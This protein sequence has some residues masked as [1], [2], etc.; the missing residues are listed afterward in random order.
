M[1]RFYDV[2]LPIYEGMVVYPG[3]PKPEFRTYASIPLEKTNE[4]LI[5]LGTHTGSHVD[6]TRHIRNDGEGTATLPLESFYG[7][8]KVLDLTSIETEI[9]KKDLEK[10]SI[11]RG[12]IILTKTMNSLRGY[13]KFRKDYVHFKKDA[14]EYL[15]RARIKTLGFDYFSVKKFEADDE[16]HEILIENLTLFEGLNLSQVPEGEYVFM[17]LPMNVDCDAAPARVVLIADQPE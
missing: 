13:K 6:T 10:Y 1:P 16:V 3:N 11:N 9:H 8:C 5:C 15:V 2:S 12:D 17:G 7:K 14:A 4:S